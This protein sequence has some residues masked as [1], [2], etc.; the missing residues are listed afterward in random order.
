M[1]IPVTFKDKLYFSSLTGYFTVR[2]SGAVSTLSELYIN[3]A[4]QL[5]NHD[6]FYK[7]QIRFMIMPLEI[8]LTRAFNMNPC[9]PDTRINVTQNINLHVSHK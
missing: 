8:S 2:K 7:I 6:K 9:Y 1:L 5:A 4:W 3:T